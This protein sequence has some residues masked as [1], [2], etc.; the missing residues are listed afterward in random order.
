MLP[1]TVTI[2]GI[3]AAWLAVTFAN[4][5]CILYPLYFQ[6]ILIDTDAAVGIIY[7]Q[8]MVYWLRVKSAKLLLASNVIIFLVGSITEVKKKCLLGMNVHLVY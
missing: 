3:G 6:T 5:V 4:V 8:F 1:V 2:P 7:V